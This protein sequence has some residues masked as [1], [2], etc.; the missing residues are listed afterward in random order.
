MRRP[1]APIL[2]LTAALVASCSPAAVTAT[3]ESRMKA[4]G[5]GSKARA[6][7]K[8]AASGPRTGGTSSPEAPADPLAAKTY[9]GRVIG[10]DGKSAAFVTVRAYKLDAAESGVISGRPPA[11]AFT[12][13]QAAA[14]LETKTKAD[15]SFLFDVPAGTRLVVEA[16]QAP[17]VKA[18]AAFA[19]KPDGNV[20]LRLARTGTLQ[21]KVT[22]S[23]APTIQD[24]QDTLVSIPGTA[25]SARADAQGAFRLDNVPV[26][27]FAVHAARADIGDG[28]LAP[29]TV[30]SG[31]TA[32]I[33]VDLGII[34]PAITA[35]EPAV[36]G[37]G[38]SVKVTGSGF[39]N[40]RGTAFTVTLGGLAVEVPSRTGE[41]A[42]SFVVP[43]AAANGDVVVTVGAIASAPSPFKVLRSLSIQANPKEL[44]AGAS[45]AF[46]A[47]GVDSQ[48]QPVATVPAIW[49][50]AG[51]AFADAS[52][53][54]TAS[55]AVGE[56][57]VEATSGTLKDT[58][59][60]KVVA[61]P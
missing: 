14:P 19:A 21:G 48:G 6:S 34:T 59:V 43:A 36:A 1:L 39:A 10:V 20:E 57:T 40:A 22:A 5:S 18:I 37:P 46:T 27:D 47:T 11:A 13:T 38:A 9:F 58:L 32:Q 23:G 16:E 7:S 17:D 55:D 53:L 25:Y 8:P 54:V 12:L 50:A 41:G 56:A 45:Q 44:A 61:A 2:L 35:L 28:K 51:A 24:F 15:G 26:G 30:A 42:L 4:A 60:V 29:V 33:T 3:T 49:T 52:G 31:Q